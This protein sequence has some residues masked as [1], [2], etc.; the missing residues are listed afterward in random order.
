[1]RKLEEIGE[2]VNCQCSLNIYKTNNYKRFVKCEVC[3]LSYPLPKR[4]SLSTSALT[5]P[6]R[7]FPVLIVS[8][9]DQKSYFWAD[10]PCFN[11]IAFDSCEVVQALIAEFKELEVNGY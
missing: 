4:G 11:C 10:Q 3:G 9:K 8:R 5:C 7:G 1:M 2:C 6:K